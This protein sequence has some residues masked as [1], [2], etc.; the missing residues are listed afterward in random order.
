MVGVWHT[1]AKMYLSKPSRWTFAPQVNRETSIWCALTDS[2][3]KIYVQRWNQ[4]LPLEDVPTKSGLQKNLDTSCKPHLKKDPCGDVFLSMNN[5]FKF[6]EL[7]VTVIASDLFCHSGC[8]ILS[9][10]GSVCSQCFWQFCGYEETNQK[11]E[12]PW[13]Q[14][15]DL[16]AILLFWMSVWRIGCRFA[17]CSHVARN[18]KKARR[19]SV[20][21]MFYWIWRSLF[22]PIQSLMSFTAEREYFLCGFRM[23]E[24]ESQCVLNVFDTFLWIW[25]IFWMFSI[26]WDHSSQCFVLWLRCATSSRPLLTGVLQGMHLDRI[27]FSGVLKRCIRQSLR[28]YVFFSVGGSFFRSEGNIWK[29]KSAFIHFCCRN[30]LPPMP[31]TP[32]HEQILRMRF[33]KGEPPGS[34]QDIC[35]KLWNNSE[36]YQ[37]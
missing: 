32:L 29:S 2:S 17:I 7:D 36:T 10:S 33:G 21:S 18:L 27:P 3:I 15:V 24:L 1:T 5:D 31:P 22:K 19:L 37:K 8:F 30:G 11:F 13:E 34:L 12:V 20:F 35:P 9:V 4:I 23:E 26:F 25:W 14:M 6:A 16:L 28:L